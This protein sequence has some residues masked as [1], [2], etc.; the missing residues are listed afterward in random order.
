MAAASLLL[1][2][3]ETE[4]FIANNYNLNGS[5]FNIHGCVIARSN[6]AKALGIPMSAPKFQYQDVINKHKVFTISGNSELYCDISNR[7]MM[8][9]CQFTPDI[10]IYS[11]DE[12][13]IN[14]DSFKQNYNIVDY[15]Q[16][17]RDVILK[18]AGIPTSIGISKT[19]TLCKIANHIAKKQTTNG[20]FDMQ[21]DIVI[22]KVLKDFPVED[23]WGIGKKLAPNLR[24]HGVGTAYELK[25]ANRG[26]IRKKFGLNTEKILL[27]LNNVRCKNI[28][29]KA[30]KK[31]IIA[32]R[33]FGTKLTKYFDVAEAVANFT[34]S[35]AERLRSQYSHANTVQLYVMTNQF[36][37]GEEQYYN[38]QT[39]ALPY[40]TSETKTLINAT[41]KMLKNI[42]YEGVKYHKAGVALLDIT[43]A[44]K[45]QS[46]LFYSHNHEQENKLSPMLDQ[47]NDKLGSNTIFF[48]SQG[49]KRKYKMK[50]DYKTNCYTTK[51]S[52]LLEI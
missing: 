23:I 17:I 10:E 44:N 16:K 27:E 20:V 19:K 1:L 5:N 31:S 12:A 21:R 29:D 9:L 26:F 36:N 15:S 22:D 24:C 35:A 49:I 28:E 45:E 25:N 41:S 4:A 39:Y 7:V 46:S 32:S 30:P 3:F 50:S 18:W 43:D 13:F 38:A 47:L 14:Y 2:S 37:H 8:T 51:W 6:E 48:G 33:S 52:E 11:I 40:P 34:A 42:F